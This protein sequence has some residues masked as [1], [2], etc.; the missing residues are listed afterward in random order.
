MAQLPL[1]SP[2][3]EASGKR[4]FADNARRRHA[5]ADDSIPRTRCRAEDLAALNEFQRALEVLTEGAEHASLYLGDNA[6][7]VSFK[8]FELSYTFWHVLDIRFEHK[9]AQKARADILMN[10]C[11]NS[12]RW[13]NRKNTVVLSCDE[14]A[15]Y[16]LNRLYDATVDH[17]CK[18]LKASA[19]K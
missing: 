3:R 11:A 14:L 4:V 2:L 7:R 10:W 15:E 16:C 6:G 9:P 13:R 1:S 17:N 12:Q 5:L 18:L 19:N 8:C